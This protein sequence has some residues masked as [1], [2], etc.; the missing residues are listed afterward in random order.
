MSSGVRS[1][2]PYIRDVPKDGKGASKKN[3]SS[4]NT[5]DP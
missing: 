3:K 2:R 4:K 1:V 5:R